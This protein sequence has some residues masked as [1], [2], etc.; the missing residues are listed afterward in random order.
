MFSLQYI[1]GVINHLKWQ[2]FDLELSVTRSSSR[3]AMSIWTCEQILRK[4]QVFGC[5]RA[6]DTKP[7][8]STFSDRFPLQRWYREIKK[9]LQ[10]AK[11]FTSLNENVLHRV[12][13]TFLHYLKYT[14]LVWT[15]LC[16]FDPVEV[17]LL[18]ILTIDNK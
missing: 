16:P 2:N 10:N 17:I 5:G 8:I 11:T 7:D 1:C 4:P 9:I 14:L 18:Q 6:I 3:W 15:L 13:D 12:T